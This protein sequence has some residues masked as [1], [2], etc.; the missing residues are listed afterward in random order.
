MTKVVWD[1][2]GERYYESG[3]SRGVFYGSDSQGVAWNGLTAVEEKGVDST[4]A[5]YID[6]FKYGDLVTLG[7][8]EGKIKAFTYPD[9]FL[10]YEGV[11]EAKEGVYLTH[12]P[13]TRFGLT[14]RT[15]VGND[16]NQPHYKLHVVYNILAI[17]ATRTHQTLSLE[18]EPNEFEWD[19]SAIPEEIDNFRP[20]A[21]VV[22]DSRNV[23]PHLLSDIENL[24]YGT[25]ETDPVLPTLQSLVT[26]VL[27][28]GRLIITDL[29]NGLWQAESPL[30]DVIVMTDATT[31]EI[32]ADTAIFLD[33]ETYEISSSDPETEDIWLP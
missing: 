4:E 9:E 33:A 11:W 6:G 5:L 26:F 10:P 28:W 3:V 1:E 25:A 32:T 2:V 16:L 15:E 23:D 13:K 31:F 8:F 17:P 21:H 30:D 29:G 24:L 7:D 14:Y 12:Q 27:K 22:I 18:T 19:I 20:T